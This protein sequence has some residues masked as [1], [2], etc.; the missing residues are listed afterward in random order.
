[1]TTY[2]RTKQQV[3][4]LPWKI[5]KRYYRHGVMFAHST[6]EAGK[7]EVINNRDGDAFDTSMSASGEGQEHANYEPPP[8]NDEPERR[9]IRRFKYISKL[10]RFIRGLFERVKPRKLTAEEIRLAEKTKERERIR[11]LRLSEIARCRQIVR[12]RL[13]DL[14]FFSQDERSRVKHGPEFNI[15]RA[16]DNEIILRCT[17]F[18]AGPGN[19]I[20]RL[21][22]DDICTALSE[23]I[24]HPVTAKY[25]RGLE[26]IGLRYFIAIAGSDGLPPVYTITEMLKDYPSTAAP[27]ALPF[28]VRTNGIPLVVDLAGMP[29]MLGGGTTGK[30]KS[31]MIHAIICTLINRNSPE[32]VLLDLLDFKDQALELAPYDGI[33]HLRLGRVIKESGQMREYFDGLQT[34]MRRRYKELERRKKRKISDYNRRIP[35][36]EK[37]IPYLV[38][39][40]DEFASCVHELGQDDA[41]RAVRKVAEQG[42]AVGIHLIVFTQYPKGDV[43]S[44][45]TTS[46]MPGR[47]SFYMPKSEQ[48]RVILESDAAHTQLGNDQLGRAIM[49]NNGKEY[50]VQTPLVTDRQISHFIAASR[51]GTAVQDIGLPIDPEEIIRWSLTVNFNRLGEREILT[52]FADREI[53]RDDFRSLLQ[54]MENEEFDI[55]GTM[56]VIRNLGGSA[57]RRV[58]LLDA[59]EKSAPKGDVAQEVPRTAHGAQNH[60]AFRADLRRVLDTH[61]AEIRAE[62][63]RGNGINMD[64]DSDLF[65]LEPAENGREW[66][67]LN[68]VKIICQ[69]HGV[70]ADEILTIMG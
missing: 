65:T 50:L 8:P 69:A 59:P 25:E 32:V 28:G 30:G 40:I 12:Q 51:S 63:F 31:N 26:H 64:I 38:V 37:R 2:T 21:A 39:I 44:S 55:D 34:E 6:P 16:N 33:P 36:G 11:M 47:V 62:K 48:S 23:S 10:V 5:A 7:T 43:I 67:L 15:G 41:E 53:S 70:G 13:I 56:Y 24:G 17:K 61:Q 18:P 54:S 14:G 22:D 19:T 49:L 42:R 4:R 9:R 29:H 60:A 35:K 46:N 58:E 66:A 20:S 1:M 52:A 27:L 3:K 57:G 45:V 68:D